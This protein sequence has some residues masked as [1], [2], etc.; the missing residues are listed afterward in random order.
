MMG[1]MIDLGHAPFLY[2][3]LNWSGLLDNVV[4]S[5]RKADAW[6]NQLKRAYP[7]R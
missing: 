2:E 6:I 3:F 4:A 7:E 1:K 5:K